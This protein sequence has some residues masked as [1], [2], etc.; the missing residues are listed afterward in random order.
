VVVFGAVVVWVVVVTGGVGRVVV[1][2]TA[3]VVVVTGATGATGAVVVTTAG[4]GVAGTA[5]VV[6]CGARWRAAG[7]LRR[8]FLWCT[9]RFAGADATVDVVLDA[10]D[11]V[12]V[13]VLAELPHPAMATVT[14]MPPRSARFIRPTPVVALGLVPQANS[15]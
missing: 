15:G 6:V 4:A 5:A 7:F 10:E 2:L 9:G 1:V 8:A 11:V 13:L 3:V 14:A 12:D